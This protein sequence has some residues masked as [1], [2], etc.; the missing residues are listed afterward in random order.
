MATIHV[1][2]LSH[3]DELIG[4]NKLVI[5]D[6]YA[7]W[8]GPCRMMAPVFET[9][10]EEYSDIAFLKVDTEAIRELSQRYVIQ[11]IP[12]V[13]AFVSGEIVIRFAGFDK[14]RLKKSLDT[15][16]HLEETPLADFNGVKLVEEEAIVLKELEKAGNK[17]FVPLDK[18]EGDWK[19]S[20]TALHVDNI[21]LSKVDKIALL[22]SLEKLTDLKSLL[23][24][25]MNLKTLP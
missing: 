23:L 18:E 4:N 24:T 17:I 25:E 22:D 3:F 19:F 5:V 10:S 21:E 20:A 8:C 7:D 12:T 9:M 14:N 2:D 11:S 1:K 6:Y 16:R 15:L 13:Q